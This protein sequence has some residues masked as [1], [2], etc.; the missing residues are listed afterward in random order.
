MAKTIWIELDPV[1]MSQLREI[2]GND[3]STLLL[4]NTII[5][6]KKPCSALPDSAY[7]AMVQDINALHEKRAKKWKG[8]MWNHLGQKM[9]IRHVDGLFERSDGL[10]II[11]HT[12]YNIMTE[13]GVCELSSR[14]K[15]FETLGSVSSEAE[16]E[17]V[18]SSAT[19]GN[20]TGHHNARK[21]KIKIPARWDGIRQ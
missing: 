19:L 3:R 6:E 15:E 16:F 8:H 2:T 4:L 1:T 20:L 7:R 13:N 11:P 10:V 21:H 5:T 18:V 14:M 17:D 9:N 12:V